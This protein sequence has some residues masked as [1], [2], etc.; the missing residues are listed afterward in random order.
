VKTMGMAA[1]AA[2]ACNIAALFATITATCAKCRQ[3]M[4]LALR[5][6]IFDGQILAFN[7]TDLFHAASPAQPECSTVMSRGTSKAQIFK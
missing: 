5:P 2:F 3:R 1:V 7:I 4:V 6:A